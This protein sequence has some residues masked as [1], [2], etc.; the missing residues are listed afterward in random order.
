MTDWANCPAVESVPGKVSGH[1]VFRDTRLQV[2]S[3]FE[4]LAAGATIYDF[5]EWFDVAGESE[6][7]AVLEYVAQDLR[8][9]VPPAHPHPVIDWGKCPG[10]ES[11]PERVSGNWV[12][13]DGRLPVYSLF[14]NLV[15]G[16]TIAEFMDWFH[17]VDERKVKAVLQYVAH[18][19]KNP[20]R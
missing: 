11:V 15:G 1:W 17:P 8:A 18:S 12:F 6:L 4:N 3:L 7:Q 5:M 14:E 9:G 20:S 16:A 2:Y 13:T 19:L 10:I